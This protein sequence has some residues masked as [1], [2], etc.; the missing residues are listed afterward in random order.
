M[1]Q[2]FQNEWDATML[3]CYSLKQQLNLARQQ[4]AHA[5][6]QQ[7]AACRVIARLTRE[8]DEARRALSTAQAQVH[9]SVGGQAES[10]DVEGNGIPEQVKQRLLS[11]SKQLTAERKKRSPPKETASEDQVKSL[12][13]VS[14]N[15]THS[16]S[17]PGILCLDL[18][19]NQQLAVTGGVD[20]NV[21]VFNREAGVASAPLSGHTKRVNSV[22]FHHERAALLSA[23]HDGTVRVWSAPQDSA[24]ENGIPH[25]AAAAQL[26][27]HAG[28]EVV[29]V[30]LHPTGDYFASASTNG[31]WAFADLSST[32]VLASVAAP[33]DGEAIHTASF[34]PDGLIFGSG[35]STGKVRV[36]DMKTL[37]NVA[38]FGDHTA[39]VRSIAFSEN[40][41]YMASASDDHTVRLW[42]LRKLKAFQTISLPHSDLTSVQFDYSGKYLAVGGSDI[43]VYGFPS[44]NAKAVEELVTLS[45]H[46]AQVT[47]I[48]FGRHAHLLASTSLDRTLRFFQTSD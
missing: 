48:R 4:L 35:T 21:V 24:S 11:V 12:K 7:D 33:V 39:P 2:L 18:H 15:P 40:G 20:R 28:A 27:P 26:Q 16:P 5:L 25:Y 36:W 42:D 34:H 22:A 9:P 6:Y 31:S 13:A 37:G 8:R 43:R 29:S 44:A 23:S 10:M 47:A 17:K 14:N 19:P 45:D 30:S 1:L 32:R 46:T 3:E 38:S 41:F